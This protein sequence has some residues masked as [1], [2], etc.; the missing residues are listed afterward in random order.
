MLPKSSARS[1][2]TTP[3]FTCKEKLT[4]QSIGLDLRLD[5]LKWYT[6]G[7]Q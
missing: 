1:K 7:F 5:Q 2:Y 4:V 6:S 3:L